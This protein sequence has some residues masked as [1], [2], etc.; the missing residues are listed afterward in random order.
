MTKFFLQS[1]SPVFSLYFHYVHYQSQYI[2]LLIQVQKHDQ[3]LVLSYFYSRAKKSIISFV[4][5]Y[6]NHHQLNCISLPLKTLKHITEHDITYF[7][8]PAKNQYR[9]STIKGTKNKRNNTHPTGPCLCV[10]A[11]DVTGRVHISLRGRNGSCLHPPATK[12]LPPTKC[13]YFRFVGGKEKQFPLWVLRY[14][15][16]YLKAVVCCSSVISFPSRQLGLAQDN[17]AKKKEW[18][19]KKRK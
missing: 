8:S 3:T 18:N 7:S 16:A 14:R 12:A 15:G 9:F 11:R 10:Y 4:F 1:L 19:R 13:Y 6:Q 5:S 2:S 17:A